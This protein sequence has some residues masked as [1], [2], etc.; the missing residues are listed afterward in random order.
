LRCFEK[1]VEKGVRRKGL[2]D[3]KITFLWERDRERPNHMF[4]SAKP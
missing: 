3:I 2:K 4:T 1:F